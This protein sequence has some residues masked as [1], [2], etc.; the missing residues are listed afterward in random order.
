MFDYTAYQSKGDNHV[1]LKIA[2][3]ALLLCGL[4]LAAFGLYF[5]SKFNA[6]LTYYSKPAVFE[7]QKG[8]TMVSVGRRLEAQS[9]IS[10]STAFRLYLFLHPSLVVQAGS[11]DLDSSLSLREIAERLSSG[12]GLANEVQLTL[13]EGDTAKDYAGE[14]K[15]AGVAGADGFLAAVQNFSKAA[16]YPVL[17]DKP[18][19]AGLEGY[20]FPDTYRFS[21]EASASG[22]VEKL[23]SNFNAK[24]SSGLLAKIAAGH[25]TV[26]DVV[27][28]ASIV[29][30]EV[31]RNVAAG[32]K[33][34]EAD[35]ERIQEERKL[36]AGVFYNRLKLSMPLQS[37]ATLAYATGVKKFRLSGADIKL[38]S[39]Y[40]T[41]SHPGLPP[42][43]INNPGLNSIL[44]A[45]E[46]AATDYLYFLSKPDGEA[47]FA[48]TLEEH[49]ANKA[50]YLK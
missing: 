50:K 23:L 19:G 3:L 42:G 44:A 5:S 31:G 22:I 16:D 37:D 8:E 9:I 46:P 11:F 43:P 10:S 32:T 15:A 39:P 28:L 21:K 40:N 34:S 35:M 33:L 12:K 2:L 45:V 18:A 24:L 4:G 7:V 27:R 38:S 13:A 36:V 29:E 47:V 14:L 26:F 25:R 1:R 20:L 41:Y 30:G 49:N 17:A 48:K 6:P